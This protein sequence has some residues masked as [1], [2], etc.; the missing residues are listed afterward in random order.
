MKIQR[1]PMSQNE[2]SQTKPAPGNNNSRATISD[3]AFYLIALAV[4]LKKETGLSSL[5]QYLMPGTNAA[6]NN[7]SAA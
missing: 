6:E 1:I 4:L 3:K 7:H 5:S 2:Y